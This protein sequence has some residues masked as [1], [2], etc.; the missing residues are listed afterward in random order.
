MTRSI[1]QQSFDTDAFGAPFYRIVDV[2]VAKLAEE[3][4][5]LT[6]KPPVIIDAKVPAADVA[7]SAWL[8]RHG[9]RKICTQVELL[10][11]RSDRGT[12]VEQR[13]RMR[14]AGE[15]SPWERGVTLL[16]EL[17]MSED[18]LR[19]H[20]RNITRD[21]F[22]QDPTLS[23]ESVQRLYERW[24]LNSIS[25]R[26]R[27]LRLGRSFFSFRE[28]RDSIRADLLSVL[29]KRQGHG[30]RLVAC[31][32]HHARTIGASTI[33]VVTECENVPSWTLFT[34]AGFR[35]GGFQS[36]YHLV[37]RENACERR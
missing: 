9:F 24:I 15:A 21:R 6:A 37:E 16:D 35:L 3:L 27:V 20:A 4:P 23:R 33:E 13:D 29:D 28:E 36:V 18:E 14:Q 32:I 17:S 12:D 11:A 5:A 10:W 25:G 26:C 2:D 8:L 19:A 34:E 31:L 7:T 30:G 22:N 1:V